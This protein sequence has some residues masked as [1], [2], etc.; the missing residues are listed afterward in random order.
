MDDTSSLRCN[1]TVGVNVGHDIVAP[2]L[3]LESGRSEFVVLDTLVLLQ[4]SNG[5]LGNVET[6]L[7]L[8]L[9]EVDPEL[10]P[11]AEA[12]A[13]REE[14]LHLLGG[15]PRVEGADAWVSI[16]PARSYA[17]SAGVALR[18][19]LRTRA[20]FGAD[21]LRICVESRRHGD[22]WCSYHCVNRRNGQARK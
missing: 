15:V 13:R 6:E 3:L 2:A 1:K 22:V 19:M 18:V 9:G 12:V 4:L 7:T 8:R 16:E 11:G 17:S 5:F 21:I 14:V 20:S 10:S